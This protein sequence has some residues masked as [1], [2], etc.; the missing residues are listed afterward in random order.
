MHKV[1]NIHDAL[2]RETMSHREVAADFLRNY[3]PDGVLRRIRLET[4]AI[5]KDTFVAPDQAITRVLERAPA[6]LPDPLALLDT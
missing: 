3:L 5:R 4:L 1:N 2:F 6:E